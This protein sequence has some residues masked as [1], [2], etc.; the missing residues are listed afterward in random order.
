MS[1][2]S[3]EASNAECRNVKAFGGLEYEDLLCEGFGGTVSYRAGGHSFTARKRLRNPVQ[4]RVPHKLRRVLDLSN[5]A[6]QQGDVGAARRQEARVA[7]QT[8]VS[9][10][11]AVRLAD[12]AR[13]A[14]A[15]E[16]ENRARAE[17][18]MQWDQAKIAEH[19]SP[20]GP[21]GGCGI[22]HGVHAVPNHVA[23]MDFKVVYWPP[24]AADLAKRAL[25]SQSAKGLRSSL[26]KA[27]RLRHAATQHERV[28]SCSKAKKPLLHLTTCFHA[29][30]CLCENRQGRNPRA[31]I[32]HA[33]RKVLLQLFQK[34]QPARVLYN[35][36]VAF[37]QIT[38][39]DG[40][41]FP[42]WF[43]IGMGN[44]RTGLFTVKQLWQHTVL[45]HEVV[46]LHGWY[47]Q[48][49]MYDALLDAVTVEHDW[50][51]QLFYA[52]VTDK[53]LVIGD[54]VPDRV[55]VQPVRPPVVRPLWRQTVER[56]RNLPL[57]RPL[58][59][60]DA[61]APDAGDG[62]PALLDDGL[63]DADEGDGDAASGAL[64]SAVLEAEAAE[65]DEGWVLSD[66][67]EQ[68]DV[69]SPSDARPAQPDD[70]AMS[71]DQSSPPA[72]PTPPAEPSGPRAPSPPPLPP[73]SLPPPGPSTPRVVEQQG[74]RP[75]SP[76]PHEPGPPIR[77]VE[78][79]EAVVAP[80]VVVHAAV[81][82]A[83]RRSPF[84]K[85]VQSVH[86]DGKECY[87]RLS[88][89]QGKDWKDMRG[90]CGVA[91]LMYIVQVLPLGSPMALVVQA[92]RNTKR[93]SL[94]C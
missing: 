58:A 77:E 60:A 73:P 74:Q 85:I 6:V 23:G 19:A 78:P 51:L 83:P 80:R 57:R 22:E 90:V 63:A 27:W 56:P 41:G 21:V 82:R 30:R 76:P 81:E 29:G 71:R 35:R 92:R 47:Q 44:L 68:V 38:R 36:C 7:T 8:R 53:T 55:R 79:E 37:V 25:S 70:G 5:R 11:L 40:N 1:H 75:P 62:E 50:D 13:D 65:G 67:E 94:T 46:E 12:D 89:T 33:F 48:A 17:S 26:E 88:Q 9:N 15:R 52:D 84:P 69:A 54:F 45:D 3:I 20:D 86:A 87:I 34:G 49:N 18:L 16:A 2:A 61:V 66:E 14:G 72:P 64:H 24:P 4:Q 59:V 93:M 32:P 10:A 43:H 42:L 39:T 31:P 28:P 91:S